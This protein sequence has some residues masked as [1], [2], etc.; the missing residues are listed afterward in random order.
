M[1]G[2]H[3]IKGHADAIQWD[4]IDK[5][6]GYRYLQLSLESINKS[7]KNQLKGEEVEGTIF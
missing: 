3:C 7:K 5:V 2:K 1:P 4:I 6:K